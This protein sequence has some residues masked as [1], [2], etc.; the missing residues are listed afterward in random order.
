M[1]TRTTW[2]VVPTVWLPIAA[3]LGIRGLFQFAG[4]PLA[5]FLEHPGL[6]LHL[7]FSLPAAV[8]I[9][10]LL[11]FLL[12]NFI[13]TLLEYFF[14]RFLFHLDY[15]LPDNNVALTLHFLTHGIHHYMPMDP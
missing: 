14:H 13:W 5:P 8:Y 7:L 2:Q 6:P 4:M 15:Y 12:G 3:Y 9:K 11:S 10:G 1:F